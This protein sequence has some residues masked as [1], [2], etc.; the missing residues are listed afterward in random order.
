MCVLAAAAV[1]PPPQ[2]A[3]AAND[4]RVQ[5]LITPTGAGRLLVNNG[6][7][8]WSWEACHRR[9]CK[10]F[11]GGREI[12]TK[13]APAGTVFRV[14]SHGDGGLSPEWGGRLTQVEQPGV[15]GVIRA[16]EFV[17]PLPGQWRGGWKGE[18]SEMQLS[19][20]ATATGGDC[21]TLTDPRY[22]RT[23]GGSASF[24]LDEKFVGSYLRVADRRV[25]AG[26]LFRT[27]MAVTSPYGGEVWAPS[28]NTAVCIAG[29]IAAPTGAYPGECGPPPPG[30][31]AID[32]RG[33]AFVDCQGGC[34]AALIAVQEGGRIRVT[35]TLPS[36]DALLVTPP[37]ELRVPKRTI[38][39]RL[40]TG[41]VQFAVEI[42]GK[43]VAR[44]TVFFD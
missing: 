14:E 10:P 5:A 35:R 41:R 4:L 20:C 31:A 15:D 29:Q 24:A 44:R 1:L 6:S 23:C 27:A 40:G 28:R 16:N 9:G 39:T 11:G 17:G 33:H 43:R 12:Q 2:G 37:V 26:P 34:R 7:A 19:A 21:I 8:P 30:R 13:G 32:P 18:F 3:T 38:K 42:D 36:R 22:P 25:G